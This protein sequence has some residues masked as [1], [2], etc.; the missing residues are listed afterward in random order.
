MLLLVTRRLSEN[1]SK[2]KIVINYVI[3]KRD[4]SSKEVKSEN[5]QGDNGSED[6]ECEKVRGKAVVMV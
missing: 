3:T 2:V 6:A 4:Q 1:V 5:Q